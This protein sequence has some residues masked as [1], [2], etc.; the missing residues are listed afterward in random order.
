[1]NEPKIFAESVVKYQTKSVTDRIMTAMAK[2]MSDLCVQNVLQGIPKSVDLM[3]VN[4][5]LELK[6]V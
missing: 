1:M 2:L 6:D 5:A 4:A 3:W